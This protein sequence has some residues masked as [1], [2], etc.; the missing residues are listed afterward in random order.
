MAKINDIKSYTVGV[1]NLD[2]DTREFNLQANAH[3]D[4]GRLTM[5][6]CGEIHSLP[7]PGGIPEGEYIGNF[8]VYEGGASVS[9]SG[10]LPLTEAAGLVEAFADEVRDSIA[11]GNPNTAEA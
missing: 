6:D 11:G 10:Q 5:L 8:T 4:E 9:T 2:D 3:V 1:T 7:I